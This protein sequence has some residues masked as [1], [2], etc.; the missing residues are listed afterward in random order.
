MVEECACIWQNLT[1]KCSTSQALSLNPAG[2]IS[3]SEPST[4]SSMNNSSSEN[5][6]TVN[7]IPTPNSSVQPTSLIA[8]THAN[9]PP[10]YKP[11]PG[12]YLS[13]D[14]WTTLCTRDSMILL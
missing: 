14:E 11:P 6:I 2:D 8:N 9:I 7:T 1:Q 13:I 10:L 5:V 12:D 4:Q 3:N